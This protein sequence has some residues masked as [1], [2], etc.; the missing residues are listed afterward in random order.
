[1]YCSGDPNDELEELDGD[2]EDRLK[3]HNC[4]I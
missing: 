2:G 3:D 4:G 1:M